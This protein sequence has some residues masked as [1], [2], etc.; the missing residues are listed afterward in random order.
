METEIPEEISLTEMSRIDSLEGVVGFDTAIE[1]ATVVA[2]FS[3]DL[4]SLV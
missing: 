4:I 1:A 3:Q 2:T